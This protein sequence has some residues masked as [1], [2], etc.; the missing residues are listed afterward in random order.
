MLVPAGELSIE[1]VDTDIP[2]GNTAVALTDGVLLS[3]SNAGAV[4]RTRVHT[5]TRLEKASLSTIE[6][7]A[8]ACK[9]AIQLGRLQA[10]WELASRVR[11]RPLLLALAN[12]AK[13]DL[14]PAIAIR[15]YRALGDAGMVM[16]LE[17]V[18]DVE[19]V[20]ALAGHMAVMF[21]DYDRAEEEFLRSSSPGEALQLRRD[22]LQWD[23]ALR[24]ARAIAPTEVGGISIEC[25]KQL[26]V[27]GEADKALAT[28]E[29]AERDLPP[30]DTLPGAEPTS[31]VGKLHVRVKAGL[32]RTLLKTG[33]LRRGLELARE[34]DAALARECAAILEGLKQA[35][36][37]A[38]LYIKAADWEHAASILI[39][40]RE[41]DKAAEIM[42]KVTSPRLLVAF[43]KAREQQGRY[44][45]AVEAFKRARSLDDV[46]RIYLE[47]MDRPDDAAELTR[48]TRSTA[49]ATMVA[50]YFQ[51]SDNT[52]GAVE[53]LLLA[54]RPDDAFDIA[55]SSGAM[56]VYTEVIAAGESGSFASRKGAQFVSLL[57]TCPWS[58]LPAH[59]LLP[60]RWAAQARPLASRLPPIRPP[61]AT[62]CNC[63]PF[64]TP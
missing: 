39:L 20:H 15:V 57:R 8:E 52:R 56:D 54:G 22:L 61:R 38:E 1:P 32:A 27:K 62:A 42:P 28:Y 59:L 64:S 46:V 55:V 17:A 19:D 5:H 37:A 4:T 14:Q 11:S 7:T 43:A 49:A 24:L 2:P 25:A 13:T 26:E 33:S 60:A 51:E 6:G 3:R 29:E 36:E 34:G 16:S 30:D 50:A 18:A 45:E 21:A 41:F 12:R 40:S 23:S 9:Q 35:P 48:K 47:K 63:Q 53:F 10:G 31:R 44:G 58:L